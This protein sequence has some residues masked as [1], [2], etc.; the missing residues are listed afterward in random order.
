MS[1]P[2]SLPPSSSDPG[3]VPGI[4]S[5]DILSG[6][7]RLLFLLLVLVL[8]LQSVWASA[9]RYCQHETATNSEHFGHHE[10]QHKAAATEDSNKPATDAKTIT[11][12][13]CGLCH[14]LGSVAAPVWVST[15]SLPVPAA[16]PPPTL[17]LPMASALLKAPERPKWERL[18]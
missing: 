6:M 12:L 17:S 3:P 13:D 15:A 2:T 11:D 9:A 18:A 5:R 4:G 1:A 16:L 8:P 7:S 14:S 10:H